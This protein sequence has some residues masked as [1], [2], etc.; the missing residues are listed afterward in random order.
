MLFRS[1]KQSSAAWN[2]CTS[3][4]NKRINLRY[5]LTHCS[6]LCESVIHGARD[7]F[8]DPSTPVKSSDS[9]LAAL[10][11][12]VEGIAKALICW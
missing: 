8:L 5:D 9:G 3:S 7:C 1:K 12:T 10:H 2:R 11:C 6:A 4:K